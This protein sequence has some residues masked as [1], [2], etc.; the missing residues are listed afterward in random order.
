MRKAIS[1]SLSLSLSLATYPCKISSSSSS[2]TSLTLTAIK[3][4]Q[5]HQPTPTVRLYSHPSTPTQSIVP[6][7]PV[8]KETLIH[9]GLKGTPIHST[10]AMSLNLY[11]SMA[12]SLLV[13]ENTM[14]SYVRAT[15]SSSAP[16]P[17]IGQISQLLIG[18]ATAVVV[19][20]VI[21]ISSLTVVTVICCFKR[22]RP[23]GN[24]G[25]A[26]IEPDEH[27]YDCAVQVYYNRASE[28]A[29]NHHPKFT[30]ECNPLDQIE[31]KTNTAYASGEANNH[32]SISPPKDSDRFESVDMKTNAAYAAA[33]EC[34]SVEINENVA[35]NVFARIMTATDS[36]IYDN[37]Y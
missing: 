18:C 10:A 29:N 8:I 6:R 28:Q 5:I 30:K 24:Q 21:I 15:I 7:S 26:K 4:A 16:P 19:L 22:K 27:H 14:S 12:P 34:N 35:Y 2:A 37:C 23:N 3:S 20:I 9:R 13:K 25:E 17:G 36:Q 32:C 1:V 33:N 31:M 11:H